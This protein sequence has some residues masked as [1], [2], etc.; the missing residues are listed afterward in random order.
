MTSTTTK[1]DS[2]QPASEKA[3]DLFDNWFDPIES[4]IRA[5]ARAFIEEL[6]RGE[7]DDALARRRGARSAGQTLRPPPPDVRG[8]T[9]QPDAILKS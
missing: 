3:V 4:E 1:P 9:R 8:R 2:L 7:F 6:I 5:R